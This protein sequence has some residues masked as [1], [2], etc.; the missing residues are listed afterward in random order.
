MR[1]VFEHKTQEGAKF[2]EQ[3]KCNKL[4][5]FESGEDI[6]E[7]IYREKQLKNWHRQWKKNLVS[8]MNPDWRD[9]S[10]DFTE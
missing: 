4:V 5:Y 9:L 10:E 3:Y 6:T 7:A 1:R 8:E 2:T